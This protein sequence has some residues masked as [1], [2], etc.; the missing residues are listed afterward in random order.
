M[1]KA[2]VNK[3][4]DIQKNRVYAKVP[5]QIIID[6]SEYKD[7][8]ENYAE[9]VG[10]DEE[11]SID[12]VIR[13]PGFFTIEFPDAGDTINFFFPYSMY[14]IKPDNFTQ[15]KDILTMK[16]EPSDMIYYGNFKNTDAN[17]PALSSLF[18]NGS[19]FLGNKPD[20]LISSLWQQLLKVNN[21]SVHHLEVLVSQLYVDFNK[22]SKKLIPLRLTGKEYSK[23]YIRNLKESSHELSNI[24]GFM[25]GYSNDAIRTSVS[26]KKFGENSFFEDVAGS[27]YDALEKWSE[28]EK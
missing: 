13:V 11:E 17:V 22:S 28:K 18:Q 15:N 2:K 1:S 4:L 23:Q 20:M 26:K 6:L 9:S 3:Y 25:Y 10:L 5:A 16:Y 19:K 14:I 21:V 8:E 24:S 27:N 7:P 12:S